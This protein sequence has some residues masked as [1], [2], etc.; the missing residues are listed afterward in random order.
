M[1]Q[2]EIGLVLG[3]REKQASCI[4]FIV[5][6]LLCRVSEGFVTPNVSVIPALLQGMQP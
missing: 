1:A 5:S 6:A 4:F 3:E 2:R